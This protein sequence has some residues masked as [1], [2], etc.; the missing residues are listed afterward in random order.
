M[1]DVVYKLDSARDN[2]LTAHL[3]DCDSAFIPQL[4]KRVDI[5]EYASKIARSATRFEAW[6]GDSLVGLVAV[7]CN[8][9]TLKYAFISSV[10]V[11][12]GWRGRGIAIYL[13]RWAIEHVRERGFERVRL[14]VAPENARARHLYERLRFSD[15]ALLGESVMELNI[16]VHQ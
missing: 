5:G 2:E 12:P 16:G 15:A 4:S 7:Y 3:W 14:E 1:P 9:S 8:D 11:L 13:L 10:S 6:S